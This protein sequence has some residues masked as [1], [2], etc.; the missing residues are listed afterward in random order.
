MDMDLSVADALDPLELAQ[1][2]QKS[3]ATVGQ[4]ALDLSSA[5]SSAGLAPCEAIVLDD[6]I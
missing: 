4:G 1:C 6:L 5:G 3:Q 2:E